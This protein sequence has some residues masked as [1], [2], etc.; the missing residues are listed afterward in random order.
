[1][2]TLSDLGNFLVVLLAQHYLLEIG[3]DPLFLNTLRNNRV[4]AMN[5]PGDEDLRGSGVELLGYFKD[6]GV[7]RELGFANDC[8]NRRSLKNTRHENTPILTVVSKGRVRSDVDTFAF[9]V[10]NKVVLGKERVGFD[11]VDSLIAI[12][13]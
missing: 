8:M 10:C 7:F 5:T 3:N 12:A 1:M 6:D 9:A 2:V 13:A 4:S 11:L